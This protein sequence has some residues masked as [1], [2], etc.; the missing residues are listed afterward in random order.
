MG[1][2]D[3]VFIDFSNDVSQAILF[4]VYDKTKIQGEGGNHPLGSRCR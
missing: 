4:A 1:E 2:L 3:T